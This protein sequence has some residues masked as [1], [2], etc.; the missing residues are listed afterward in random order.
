MSKRTLLIAVVV[1]VVIGL[2][3]LFRP[4]RLWVDQTVN[5]DF[6]VAGA[7]PAEA[8]AAGAGKAAAPEQPAAEGAGRTGA[9]VLASGNFH[10]VAHEGR[11]VA[12]VHQLPDGQRVLRFTEFE[13]SNG[14]DVRVY[15]VAAADADDN[16]TVQ[17]A[18]FVEIGPIKGN[19]GDQNYHLPADL[20]LSRYRSVTIWCKRFG[21]N[22]A[23]APL[24]VGGA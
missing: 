22:F 11:G 23:T 2:W 12:T 9:A 3:W 6:P 20:D 16:D 18:G 8:P 7:A 19:Q 17:R 1:V 13:T 14:P 24:S 4:E 21:V 10:G 5:E 15:M